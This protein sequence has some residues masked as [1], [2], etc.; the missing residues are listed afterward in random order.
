MSKSK[1]TAATLLLLVSFLA[2][3]GAQMATVDLAPQATTQEQTI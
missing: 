2:G 3:N 1:N